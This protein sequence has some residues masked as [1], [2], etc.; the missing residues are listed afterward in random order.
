VNKKGTVLK[1]RKRYKKKNNSAIAGKV[2]LKVSVL[3]RKRIDEIAALERL[4]VNFLC[5]YGLEWFLREYEK[6]G[7]LLEIGDS[8][9]IPRPGRKRQIHEVDE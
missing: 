6:S 7:S 3:M 5:G 9:Q 1:I 2:S 4:S 8:L